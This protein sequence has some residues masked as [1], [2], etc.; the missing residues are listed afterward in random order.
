MVETLVPEVVEDLVQEMVEALVQDLVVRQVELG[1]EL[2][3]EDPCCPRGRTCHLG[4][5]EVVPSVPPPDQT[6]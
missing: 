5:N 1:L 2:D 3:E 6:R 4:E